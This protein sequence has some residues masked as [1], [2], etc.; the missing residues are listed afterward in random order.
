VTDPAA[1]AVGAVLAAILIFVEHREAA[2]ANP[3][4]NLGN[5]GQQ[6]F[7]QL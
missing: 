3:A 1:G 5:A 6:R 2:A 4:D 7:S